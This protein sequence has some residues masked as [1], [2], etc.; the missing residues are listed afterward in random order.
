VIS[1]TFIEQTE[2]TEPHFVDWIRGSYYVEVP[3]SDGVESPVDEHDEGDEDY[4][5]VMV[6]MTISLDFTKREDREE[7]VDWTIDTRTSQICSVAAYPGIHKG[8]IRVHSQAEFYKLCWHT[9]IFSPYVSIETPYR[10]DNAKAR[11]GLVTMMSSPCRNRLIEAGINEWVYLGGGR[12]TVCVLQE[13][14]KNTA[15]LLIFGP[16]YSD[17]KSPD[18]VEYGP[19]T[20]VRGDTTLDFFKSKEFPNAA[21]FFSRAYCQEDVV[22]GC[23]LPVPERRRLMTV[24]TIES[25]FERYKIIQEPHW[26]KTTRD[27][28]VDDLREDALAVKTVGDLRKFENKW[29]TIT[30]YACDLTL[31]AGP[32][33]GRDWMSYT[34]PK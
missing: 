9:P 28:W 33:A 17:M 20:P 22:E 2:R 18:V 25:M 1:E 21:A 10:T 11:F 12:M 15:R 34:A 32:W 6:K 5:E 14:L 30:S 23:D 8:A 13:V 16:R 19:V 7:F 24:Q 4:A 3:L 31:H 29:A 26:I 27:D